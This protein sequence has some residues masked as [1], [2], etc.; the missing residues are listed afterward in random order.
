[1]HIPIAEWRS[2]T[3]HPGQRDSLISLFEEEFLESQDEV[4]ARVLGQ[5]RVDGDPHKFVWLRGFSGMDARQEALMNFYNGPIWQQHRVAANATM[6][7]SDDVHLLNAALVDPLPAP[8]P[9]R[10]A[11]HQTATQFLALVCRPKDPTMTEHFAHELRKYLEESG[12]D[13]VGGFS[14]LDAVNNFPALPVWADD[15]VHIVLLRFDNAD[16]LRAWFRQLPGHLLGQLKGAPQSLVLLPTAR[17]A[18]R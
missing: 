3:L 6:I 18:L 17:S 7:D 8:R 11:V 16:A 5:F 9:A 1:M 13:I 12:G 10:G 2:Y 15:P 4:G 14:T